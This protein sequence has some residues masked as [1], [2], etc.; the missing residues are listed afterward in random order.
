MAIALSKD[1]SILA[2]T[3]GMKEE[4]CQ[5]WVS[6]RRW[7]YARRASRR[8]QS[9]LHWSNGRMPSSDDRQPTGNFIVGSRTERVGIILVTYLGVDGEACYIQH[10]IHVYEYRRAMGKAMVGLLKQD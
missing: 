2:V 10:H 3:Q 5:R 4:W 9:S 6:I 1:P 8:G 7:C